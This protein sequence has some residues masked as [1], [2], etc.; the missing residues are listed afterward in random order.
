MSDLRVIL[1]E[2]PSM[3]AAIAQALGL[4]SKGKGYIEGTDP[5]GKPT[6]CTWAIGHL[7]EAVAPEKYDPAWEKWTWD[8]LPMIP[9]AFK[10]QV[11]TKTKDQFDIIKA[12]LAKATE[13]VVATDAGREGELIASLIIDK[14]KCKAKTLRLWTKS[15]TEEAVREAYSNM[16]PWDSYKGLRDA[17]YGRSMADWLVGMTGSRAMTL[18]ARGLGRQE[19]GAWPVGRVMT[20]TL[21]LLVDRELEIQKF[22]SKDF[23]VLEATFLHPAGTYKGKWF[24]G[25]QDRFDKPE[26]AQALL[27]ALKGRPARVSKFETRKESKAPEQFYD[28]TTLQKEANKR[29]HF[30]SEKTLGLAQSLY[31]KKV[32][33]Y[34]RTGSRYLTV[35]DAAKI[36]AWLNTLKK[37]S[38][39]AGFVGEI[40]SS[41]LGKRFVDDAEVEDHTALMPTEEAPNWASLSD[42]EQKIYDMVARRFIAAFFPDRIEVKTTLITEILAEAGPETF[43]ATGTAVLDPGWSRIDA[44]AQSKAKKRSKKGDEEESEAEKPLVLSGAPMKAGDPAKVTELGSLAKKTA[45]PKRM[46]EADLLAA[47]QSAGK[48]LDEEELRAAMKECSGIGTPATRAATIEKLVDKGTAKYPKVPLVE[49]QKNFLIPGQ[50]GIDL[51]LMLPFKELRSAELTARWE[52]ELEAINKGKEN[53]PAFVKRIEQ[54]THD[55]TKALRGGA[56]GTSGDGMDE[57]HTPAP[58]RGAPQPLAEP[59]PKCGQAVHLKSWEGRYY[60]K[61]SNKE[62]YF[63]FDTDPKGIP[64]VK[65]KAC[66]GRVKTTPNGGKVCADCGQWQDKIGAPGGDG[67]RPANAA[68]PVALG[69]CPRCSKGTLK[70]RQ[71]DNGFW[72]GCSE[73]DACGLTYDS[74]RAGKP[75]SGLHAKC[76]GP[77]K[78]FRS[79]KKRCTVCDEWISQ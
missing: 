59:C 36:P 26:E 58:P 37:L 49:R 31:D 10:Y 48:D 30:S 46:T 43:K 53:L 14:A 17:A 60:T 4:R 61:C 45:P 28:L 16:K 78:T 2:K 68:P 54:Y 38:Q 1:A 66:Q 73:R 40:T 67:A 56:D 47:M 62:C 32:M 3:G 25:D 75:N 35:A 6:I 79:G 19:K 27:S 21:A 33:S 65:C 29:F 8:I 39:F 70:V 24:R 34:P 74:D 42:D 13:V 71:G 77:I 63:G 69:K 44:P 11:V 76:Q 51:V 15:L 22:V 64:S 72:V 50:K 12:Q 20:P 57:N 52:T 55:M 41:T 7:V 18:R 23:F 5:K 9:E